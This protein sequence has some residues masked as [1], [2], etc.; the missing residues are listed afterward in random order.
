MNEAALRTL[1]EKKE[2]AT[3]N[4]VGV[5]IHAIGNLNMNDHPAALRTLMHGLDLYMEADRAIT[6]F[7][8][9]QVRK[10]SQSEKENSHVSSNTDTA[11]A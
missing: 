8:R 2:L 11:A 9:D 5:V 4:M 6:E 7:Q 3:L 10:N 1:L